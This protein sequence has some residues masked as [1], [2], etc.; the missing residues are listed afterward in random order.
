MALV[1]EVLNE[2][3]ANGPY[4]WPGGYPVYFLAKDGEALSFEA[5]KDNIEIVR[6]ATANPGTDPQWEI[7]FY[8]INWEDDNLYCSHTGNKIECAYPNESETEE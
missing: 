5:V 7:V 2:V 6:E 1:L 8:D 4:A 3:V